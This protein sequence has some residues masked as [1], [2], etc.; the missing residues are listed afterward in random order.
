MEQ[1]SR[2]QISEG[3]IFGYWNLEE[4][5]RGSDSQSV[6]LLSDRVELLK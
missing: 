3:M 6:L 5:W 4:E 2:L 1:Q